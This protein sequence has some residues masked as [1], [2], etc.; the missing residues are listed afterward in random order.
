VG[1][2]ENVQFHSHFWAHPSFQGNW[3]RV[4]KFMQEN[5]EAFIFGRTD[6]EYVNNTFVF[7]ARVGYRFIET[8]NGACNGQF[9]GIGADATAT[10]IEAESLQPQGIAIVNGEFNSHQVG[11]ATQ[12]I[13]EK[14]CRGNIRFLNCGF[15]GPVEQNVL[16]A[17]PS[18]LSF[19]NCYFSNDR[20]TTNYSIVAEKGRLQVTGCTFDARSKRRR[21][22]NSW[23]ENDARS[24]PGGVCVKTGVRHA[25]ITGNN[26]YYGVS[27]KNE[28]GTNAIIRDNEAF[29]PPQR[30]ASE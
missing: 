12:I 20:D 16:L 15:W 26:G 5:L 7:P 17:G 18:F 21:P 9:S 1:R 23:D 2:I 8:T 6:W 13:V 27:I 10:C 28:I 19:D 11:P 14:S 29:E 24:Q 22:G 30:H 25:I 3:D 4:F